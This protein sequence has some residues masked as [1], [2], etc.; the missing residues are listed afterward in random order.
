V[1]KKEDG[2]MRKNPDKI[3]F[4]CGQPIEDRTYRSAC[5]CSRCYTEHRKE[6]FREYQQLKRLESSKLEIIAAGML[7]QNYLEV[8]ANGIGNV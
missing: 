1:E 3:C 4:K 8:S 6:Y 7:T 5:Y 2:E